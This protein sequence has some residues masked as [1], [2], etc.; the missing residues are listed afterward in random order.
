M[1]VDK[2]L[3]TISIDEL[4]NLKLDENNQLYWQDKPIVTKKKVSLRGYELLL[5]TIVAL[6]TAIQGYVAW[7][8][9]K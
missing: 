3:R 2:T 6:A 4:D 7:K 1:S 5:A 8:G 9:I